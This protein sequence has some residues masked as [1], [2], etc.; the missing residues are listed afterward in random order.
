M[1]SAGRQRVA[2]LLRTT[3]LGNG[4]GSALETRIVY[5]FPSAAAALSKPQ[6]GG[7]LLVMQETAQLAPAAEY[8]DKV[9]KRAQPL[10]NLLP[11]PERKGKRRKGEAG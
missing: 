6:C 7:A 10:T 11:T 5:D 3:L 9:S 8:Y 2:A 1:T 4:A